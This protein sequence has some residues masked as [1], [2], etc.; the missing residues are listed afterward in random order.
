MNRTQF[1][2]SQVSEEKVIALTEP[3]PRRNNMCIMQQGVNTRS[4][5]LRN[6]RLPFDT[7]T[8]ILSRIRGWRD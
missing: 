8:A 1:E 7:Q 2:V 6:K 3:L 4:L 5:T